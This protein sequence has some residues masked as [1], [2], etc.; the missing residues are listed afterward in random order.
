AS[1]DWITVD[2]V[3][4][5]V[6]E[7]VGVKDMK[8]IHK[9]IAHGVGWLGD[10]KKIALKIERLKALGFKPKL[11]SAQAVKETVLGMM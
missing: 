6:I 1:E 2:E 8:I 7:T 4:K 5:I 3:T 9:P 11:N 10:V